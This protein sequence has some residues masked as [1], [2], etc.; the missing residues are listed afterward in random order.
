[1]ESLSDSSL[2]L[3]DQFLH[4]DCEDTSLSASSISLQVLP[5]VPPLLD[6]GSPATMNSCS[7]L[8]EHYETSLS[9]SKLSQQVLPLVVQS[10]DDGSQ[11]TEPYGDSHATEAHRAP[12]HQ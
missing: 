8:V 12:M 2:S 11:S 3:Q 1:M 6:G 9:A 4:E 10:W 7:S 5:L